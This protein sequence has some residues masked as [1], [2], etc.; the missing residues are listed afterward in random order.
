MRNLAI[1]LLFL[2]FFGC[3]Y[4]EKIDEDVKSNSTI[5]YNF[6]YKNITV[7]EFDEQL[8]NKDFFLVDVHTPEQEHINGTDLFIPYDQI[9]Q[10]ISE[11]P[12]D[13]D[14]KIVLYCR[15]GRM[16]EIAGEKLAEKGYTNIYNVLGGKKTYD[17]LTQELKKEERELI[18]DQTA[19]EEGINLSIK[20]ADIGPKIIQSGALD[21]DIFEELMKNNGHSLTDDQRQIL[22]YGSDQYITIN[23][24]NNLFLLDVMWA[25]GLVNNNSILYNGAISN[26][27]TNKNNFAST[28]GWPLGKKPGG[29]L[30]SSSNILILTQEQQ[31]KVETI[32]SNVYRPC[33]NNPTSFPDCN[34]GMASLGLTQLMVYNNMSEDDI[35]RNLLYANS[36]WFPRT[37]VD[38]GQ[39]LKEQGKDWDSVDAKE[40]LGFDYSSYSGYASIRSRLQ[41]SSIVSSDAS[42][43]A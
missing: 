3:T 42:C 39:Y 36:Y 6:S 43:G 29:E 14:A 31:K 21:Y 8:K 30:L 32:T 13:K 26:S 9:I 38:I 18:Y 4:N 19:T 2:L 12:Q 27:Q 5:S 25:F 33:C 23:R 11:L 17:N 7:E 1:L 22:L 24:T 16:S 34:H 15:S 10:R 20:W 35:Y 28:G 37:Y 40:I 41:N